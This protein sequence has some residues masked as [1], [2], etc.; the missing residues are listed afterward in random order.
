MKSFN[1]SLGL[2]WLVRQWGSWRNR[3][4][5]K[6]EEEESEEKKGREKFG[7]SDRRWIHF[8]FNW[9]WQLVYPI[10]DT[11]K[12]TIRVYGYGNIYICLTAWFK[13]EW[14][15]K[16]PSDSFYVT[17]LWFYFYFIFERCSCV[18]LLCPGIFHN[19][20]FIFTEDICL[21]YKTKVVRF[22]GKQSCLLRIILMHVRERER[23]HLPFFLNDIIKKKKKSY[24]I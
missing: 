6:W 15:L 10:S 19:P 1:G 21:V 9:F 7:K 2:V 17:L 12:N 20:Y 23:E 11:F 5:R 16:P 22:S 13:I 8:H 3:E 4:E 24:C 18:I 14:L